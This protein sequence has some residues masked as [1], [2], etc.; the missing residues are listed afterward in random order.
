MPDKRDLDNRGSIVLLTAVALQCLEITRDYAERSNI[1]EIILAI[2]QHFS[3]FFK[4][5]RALA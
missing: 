1:K 5:C 3:G 2:M 4:H